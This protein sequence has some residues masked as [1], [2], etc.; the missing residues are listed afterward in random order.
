MN[1]EAPPLTDKQ[2][3]QK[4]AVQ[5]RRAEAGAGDRGVYWA[6]LLASALGG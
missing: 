4:L 3:Y 1:L 5:M 6:A 2:R